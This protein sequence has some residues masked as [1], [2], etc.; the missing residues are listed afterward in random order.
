MGYAGLAQ[1]GD[2]VGQYGALLF[3][4]RTVL[5]KELRTIDLVEVVGVTNAGGLEPVGFVDVQPLVDQVDGVGNATPHGVLHHLPYFR[6][7]GGTDAA[8]LDPKVGDIGMAAFASRDISSVKA[9]KAQATP[10]SNRSFDMADGLYFGGL[11]NGTPTQYVRFSPDGIEIVSPTSIRL[12]A[13]NIVLQ[14][15]EAIGLT[16]GTTITNSA[17]LI[18]LDGELTQGEGP[19]GGNASMHGP[20]NVETDVTANGTS[21]HTHTHGGVQTGG[22]NTGAPN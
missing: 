17:P 7:Q 10:G 18:E 19:Q 20:L 6:L 1:P 3:L 21:L 4:I 15:T 5:L 11:L 14:A 9:T 12:A 8:I 16:A 2:G 13:P 22:G